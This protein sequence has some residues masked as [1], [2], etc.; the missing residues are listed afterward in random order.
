MITWY[1][2]VAVV[3]ILIII[4]VIHITTRG[5]KDIGDYIVDYIKITILLF[6]LILFI[7]IWGGIFW[8]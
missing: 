1:N 8:W 7:A 3:V 6:I 5:P 4:T 2:I